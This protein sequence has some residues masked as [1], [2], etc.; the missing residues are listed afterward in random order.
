MKK[1]LSFVVFA[2][3]TCLGFAQQNATCDV[4]ISG[5][6][7]ESNLDKV[8]L[9]VDNGGSCG[10]AHPVYECVDCSSEVPLF[11]YYMG[12]GWVVSDEECSVTLGAFFA[13]SLAETPDQVEPGSWQELIGTDLTF[14]DAITSECAYAPP[15]VEPC[16]VVLA[17]EVDPVNEDKMGTYSFTGDNCGDRPLYEKKVFLSKTYFLY[18]KGSGWIVSNKACSAKFAALFAEDIAETADQIA[19]ESWQ[20]AEGTRVRFQQ[21]RIV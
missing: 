10:D 19:P 7:D 13:T 1:G 14:N 11:L 15:P 20:E 4:L 17:G 16:E 8:G 9:Y 18:H 6:V 2:L 21:L 3:A 5:E 12:G